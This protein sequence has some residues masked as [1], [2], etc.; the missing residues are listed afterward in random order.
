MPILTTNSAVWWQMRKR[1]G[2]DVRGKK[3]LMVGLMA[4][5]LAACSSPP[6]LSEPEGDWVSFETP[7]SAAPRVTTAA[8]SPVRQSVAASGSYI[9]P[10]PPPISSSARPAVLTSLVTADGK[11]VPLYMAVRTVV[12]PSENVRLSP[13]VAQNF[14]TNVS[15]TGN[16]QWPFV[17]QKMLRANGLEAVIDDKKHEVVIQYGQKAGVPVKPVIPA[18]ASV[19]KTAPLIP[20]SAAKPKGGLLQTPVVPVVTQGA[21]VPAAKKP[22]A[23]PV[24]PVLPVTKTWTASKGTTLKAT[25]LAWAAKEKCPAG[26]KVWEVRWETDTNYP[27]DYPLTFSSSSFENVTTQLFDLYRR[28]PAPVYVHGYRNQCLIIINDTK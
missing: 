19:T 6:K 9:Q 1:K 10:A 23:V 21:S 13:D 5:A 20:A 22:P 27:I 7:Y 16:D 24:A 18:A 25:Y 14:R 26:G 28:A 11:N 8:G 3:L 15:W 12:P 4:N 17:L 2:C